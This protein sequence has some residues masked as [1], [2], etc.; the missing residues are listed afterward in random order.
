MLELFRHLS[1]D[2]IGYRHL[3]VWYLALFVHCPGLVRRYVPIRVDCLN[4]RSRTTDSRSLV[5]SHLCKTYSFM[6]TRQLLVALCLHGVGCQS[7]IWQVL[8]AIVQNRLVNSVRLKIHL[9]VS[10]SAHV[11][12]QFSLRY[13]RKTSTDHT[14]G[15]HSRCDV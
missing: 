5:G 13:D 6:I 9:K 12:K 10:W 2:H 7:R 15:R 11:V 8:A 14:P 1:V 3:T 4:F